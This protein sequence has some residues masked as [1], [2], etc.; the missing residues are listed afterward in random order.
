MIKGT[1][2]EAIDISIASLTEST[3]K[4][5]NGTLKLWWRWNGQNDEDPYVVSVAKILKFLSERFDDGVGYSTL[6]S[7]KAALSLISAEDITNNQLIS[8]FNKG[9]SKIRPSLPNYESTWDVDPVLDVGNVVSV[10]GVIFR[11]TNEK[12]SV[13]ISLGY[14]PSLSNVFV[15]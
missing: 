6:N 10:R 12:I 11:E 15:N 3:L 4:N 1:P 13:V 5:Y 8:R 2:R 9:S 14:R 7:A